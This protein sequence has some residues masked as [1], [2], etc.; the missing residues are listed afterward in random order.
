[1]DGT[2]AFRFYRF[3]TKETLWQALMKTLEIQQYN[4]ARVTGGAEVALDAVG[5]RALSLGIRKC[6]DVG[7]RGRERS[8][9]ARWRSFCYRISSAFIGADR[10]P[11]FF[12]IRKALRREYL[13]KGKLPITR[14][15]HRLVLAS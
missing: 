15:Q 14:L 3:S 4:S 10:S 5:S 12:E 1:M 6:A 2:E 13:R 9:L 8:L 11:I 7:T